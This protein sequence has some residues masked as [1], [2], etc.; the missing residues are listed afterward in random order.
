MIFIVCQRVILIYFSAKSEMVARLRG[1]DRFF[2]H[3]QSKKSA[4]A[5]QAS[6]HALFGPTPSVRYI[7]YTNQFQELFSPI[8]HW[9]RPV[10][11]ARD[12]AM[13][14]ENWIPLTSSGTQH[15]GRKQSIS[16][17][18]IPKFHS[19]RVYTGN[20]SSVDVLRKAVKNRNHG[21]RA[22]VSLS[23]DIHWVDSTPENDNFLIF[24]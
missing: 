15:R 14:I 21:V 5:T 12:P 20:I 7:P 13:L 18:G 22:G 10:L 6:N 23:F 2:C 8:R 19:R 4:M 1:H 9:L 17:F 16:F 11:Y 24:P 3:V